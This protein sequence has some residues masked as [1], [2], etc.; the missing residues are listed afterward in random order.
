MNIFSDE[1]AGGGET[2]D[3]LRRE[4]AA[5]RRELDECRNAIDQ[6]KVPAGTGLALEIAE[7][8]KSE[9]ILR[10][11]K[12]VLEFTLE[13]AQVGDWDLD[14]INDTSR[15]SLRHDQCF[16]YTT[17]I[18]EAQWG[19]EEFIQHVHPED[20]A[21]VEGSLRGAAKDLLDWSAE[22]RVVWPDGSLHWISAS[23]S[24]YRTREGK[25]TRMLGIVMDVTDRKYA[26]EVLRASGRLARRHVEALTRTLDTLAM[27]PAPER[28]VSHILQAITGQFDAHSS[29]VW[30]R[31]AVSGLVT[32]E[33]AFEGGKILA[34]TDTKFAGMALGLPME[35]RW[36]WPEVFLTGKPSVIDDIRNVPPFPLRDRLLA[37][38]IVTVLLIPMSMAG[39][40]EGAIGLRF[41]RKR[42][43]REEEIDLGQV[44]AN[45]AMLAMH[46][47]RLSVESRETAVIAER[48]R[49]ARDIHDT[50]AQGFTGVILQLEAAKGAAA[51]NDLPVL[52]K[53]IEQA[54]D[55][56]RSSL[57][58][59]RR[60]VQALRPRSLSDGTLFTALDGLLKR[61]SDGTS[62]TADFRIE[63]EPRLI[64]ADCE[65]ALL[66][67][68][69]ESLTNTIKHARARNFQASLSFRPTDIQ[70]R[71]VDDGRGFEVGK[72][73]DGFGLIGMKERVTQI[74]GQFS[75]HS[76]AGEGAEILVCL[77]AVKESNPHFAN[78]ST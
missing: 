61:M 11:T 7:R 5:C 55:L 35:D 40:L 28:L 14:L 59:A 51:N 74:G 78:E 49:M 68:T 34:K 12:A 72:E 15:R 27:E 41:D 26:E 70:L 32:F 4:L 73:T 17:A 33:F 10:E 65:E 43:F 30:R 6:A 20:R 2:V 36:P 42:T 29:S 77:G 54:S 19:I 37:L 45:Q 23:G 71:L 53:R 46:L 62:L 76:Q 18:P 60:S 39:R 56:A 57:G 69:Q 25:A 22:F 52:I 50:L 31:D 67:V 21:R 1:N 8:S 38:G 24:T 3:S 9:E 63:G 64:S 66:R 47:N 48:N 16:G 75:V 13:S 58:E 44:L